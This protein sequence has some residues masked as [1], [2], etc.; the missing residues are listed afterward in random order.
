METLNH[1]GFDVVTLGNHEFDV[2]NRK[3]HSVGQDIHAEARAGYRLLEGVGWGV[4][5]RSI[6]SYSLQH[7]AIFTQMIHAFAKCWYLILCFPITGRNILPRTLGTNSMGPVFRES[8]MYL[9]Q[10]TDLKG[11]IALIHIGYKVD[12]Y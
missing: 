12:A 10:V 4:G 5:D 2:N 6:G 8:F 7:L 1:G 9:K 3:V 11:V